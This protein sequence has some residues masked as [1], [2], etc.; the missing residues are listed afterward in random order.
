MVSG[1]LGGGASLAGDV[2]IAQWGQ[3]FYDGPLSLTSRALEVSLAPQ[4][5]L[6]SQAFLVSQGALGSTVPM[7][8]DLQAFLVCLERKGPLVFLAPR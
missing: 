6:V 2:I 8:Q 3:V 7:L 4:D 5:P 1:T